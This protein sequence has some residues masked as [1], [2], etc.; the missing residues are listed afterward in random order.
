MTLGAS[1]AASSVETI[2]LFTME[3]AMTA[4]TKT[5]WLCGAAQRFASNSGNFPAL[6]APPAVPERG[7]TPGVETN[8]VAVLSFARYIDARSLDAA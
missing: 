1:G 4:M 8:R 6:D 7:A 2:Q 5:Y 3:E